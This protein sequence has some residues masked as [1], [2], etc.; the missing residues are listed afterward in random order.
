M[1]HKRTAFIVMLGLAL[2]GTSVYAAG[3]D[4]LAVFERFESR[5]RSQLPNGWKVDWDVARPY[6]AAKAPGPARE[7]CDDEAP[8]LLIMSADKLPIETVFPG[9]APGQEPF[10]ESRQVMVV[11]EVRPY[12]TPEE[13]AHRKAK[14]NE[15]IKSREMAERKLRDTSWVYKGASPVPPSAFRPRDKNERRRVLE[16]SLLWNRTEPERLPTHFFENLAF[17]VRYPFSESLITDKPRA[18]QYEAI[19]K[20]VEATLKPY[21]RRD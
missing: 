6:L 2:V 10:R 18:K 21:E 13:F 8:A 7:G 20:L 17:D 16:Y 19:V 12:L 15:L 14:D 5:I 3:D 9:S 11:L 1:S 4:Q